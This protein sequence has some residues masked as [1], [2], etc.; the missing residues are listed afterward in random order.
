[1]KN[2]YR[3][4]VVVTNEE[5]VRVFYDQGGR[6]YNYFDCYKENTADWCEKNDIKSEN[7]PIWADRVRK[8]KVVEVEEVEEDEEDE[9]YY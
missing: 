3:Y 8:P 2:G 1:M 5:G 6:V 4:P 7:F 9:E